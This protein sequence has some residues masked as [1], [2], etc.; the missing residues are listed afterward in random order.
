MIGFA[1]LVISPVPMVRTFGA[2]VALGILLSL[3]LT[4]VLGS[5]LLRGD[6]LSPPRR[7]R[8]QAAP[9]SAH[10][11]VTIDRLRQGAREWCWAWRRSLALLGWVLAP[12][13]QTV[14]GLDRLAPATSARLRTW[15]RSSGKAT[16]SGV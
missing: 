4:L 1:A 15:T 13:S 5:A 11:M 8:S 14:S 9:P 12:H 6:A 10:R 7:R 3:V 16:W 2:F